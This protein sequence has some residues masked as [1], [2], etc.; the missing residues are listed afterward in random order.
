M[1]TFA[2][3]DEL[4]NVTVLYDGIESIGAEP[5]ALADLDTA[6]TF[7]R[8]RAGEGWWPAIDLL[9]SYSHQYEDEAHRALAETAVR[10]ARR[11]AD[12]HL[13]YHNQGMA[14]FDMAYY[15]EAERQAIIRGRR[16]HR[17]LSQP[18]TVAE[19]WSGTPAA[20]V[21]LPETMSTVQA[22]LNGELDE[23]PEEEL[24]MISQWSP[25]WT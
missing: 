2:A 9:R 6:V 18:L 8:L 3:L 20:Y 5:T 12:L 15:G 22:I 16:L 24:M 17:F 7:D 1:S 21:P 25:V 13:I 14:G 10:L 23:V 19:P 11:Y 4:A